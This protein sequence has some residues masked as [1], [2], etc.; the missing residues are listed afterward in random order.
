MTVAHPEERSVKEYRVSWEMWPF[1]WPAPQRTERVTVDEESA[2]QQLAGLRSM[3]APHPP[4][5][6]DKHVWDIRFEI[7]E[8]Q[9]GN[10]QEE[11][12]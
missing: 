3:E 2:R 6:C 5:Q 8:V 1:V 12:P 7:R 11:A 10:W 4:R 9:Q